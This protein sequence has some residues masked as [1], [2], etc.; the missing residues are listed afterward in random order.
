MA[1]I[2]GVIIAREGEVESSSLQLENDF[3]LL[4]F[5]SLPIVVQLVVA[6][7]WAYHNRNFD[8]VDMTDVC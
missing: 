2:V 5:D 4:D 7:E 6:A 3:L 8:G 1:K